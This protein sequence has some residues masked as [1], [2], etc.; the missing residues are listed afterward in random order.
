MTQMA[1]RFIIKEHN[2]FNDLKDIVMADNPE[3]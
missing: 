2:Y 1:E 3:K